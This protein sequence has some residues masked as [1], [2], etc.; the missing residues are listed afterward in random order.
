MKYRIYL[1]LLCLLLAA[2][3]QEQG[4]STGKPIQRIVKSAKGDADAAANSTN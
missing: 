4:G 3:A 1:T 2:A